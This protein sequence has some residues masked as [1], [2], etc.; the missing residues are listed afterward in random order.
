VAHDALEGRVA[1]ERGQHLRIVD[2][3]QVELRGQDHGGGHE[4]P[5]QR[6]APGL[7][8]AGD[9]AEALLPQTALVAPEVQD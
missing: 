6:P 1:L 2:P 9:Q 4:R 3:L 8:D 7:V 5:G